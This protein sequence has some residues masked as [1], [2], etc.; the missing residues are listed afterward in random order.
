MSLADQTN[1]DILI[2]NVTTIDAISR[3]QANQ[4]VLIKD[5]QISMIDNAGKI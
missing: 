4:S 2:Q 1:H 3:K 5:G